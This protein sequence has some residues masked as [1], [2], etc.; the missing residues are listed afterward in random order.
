M[1]AVLGIAA[2]TLGLACILADDRISR[3]VWRD[4][5]GSESGTTSIRVLGFILFVAGGVAL[6]S[7]NP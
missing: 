5:E 3:A 4:T 2:I 6:L 7:W 1:P